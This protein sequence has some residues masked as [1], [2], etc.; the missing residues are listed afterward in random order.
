MPSMQNV[1]AV[2]SRLI[3]I[4][5][6]LQGGRLGEAEQACQ[7]LLAGAPNHPDAVHMLGLIREQA[8]DASAGEQLVRKSL[9]LE[10]GNAQYLLNLAH[11]L[12]RRGRLPEAAQ[13]YRQSLA[14][15]PAERAARYSLAVTL[16]DLGQH[17]DAERECRTLLEQGAEDADAWA[18]LAFVLGDQGRLPEAELAYRRALSID[19]KHV[20]AH[21]NLGS[22]LSRMERAE[23]ALAAL[24][25]ARALGASGFELNFNRGRT[26][27]L[28]YRLDEAER[29]FIEA[30]KLRPF[31]IDAQVNLA[32]LRFMRADAAFARDI[33]AAATAQPGNVP[34]QTAFA[35]VLKG[36]GAVELAERH[37]RQ[38]MRERGALP[39]LRS[40][41]AQLLHEAGRLAEA[42]T[43]ALEA[44]AARPGDSLIIDTLVLILLS[45]GRAHDALAFLV[46]QRRREPLV[47]SW[48]AYEATAA[49]LL[50]RDE[51]R[52]LYDYDWLVR[53]FELE[54]PPGWTSMA[55][56]NAALRAALQPRHQLA[57]HPL[58]QS[59]RHGSQTTRNLLSEDDAAIKA[60][61][62]AFEQPIAAYLRELGDAPS[63][64]LAARNRGSAAITGAWSVQLNREGFHVNH[65]HPQGWIS[66]AYYVNVPAEVQDPALKSG[67]LKFGETRF[68]V[69]GATPERFI[70]PVPGR[71][72]LFPSY[73][74]H[75]TNPIHGREPRLSIAFDA[76]PNLD[77]R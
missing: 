7:A 24:E 43:E 3:A 4:T 65:L 57:L 9:S 34:L 35:T 38:S 18:L 77:A 47:Q 45:R 53:C 26:L 2:Q 37:L 16:S 62:R 73:M 75:G 64:P 32:R 14:R 69:P 44:A 20:F 71:L 59:L 50:G 15:T 48:I 46:P 49:R 66:S 30:L 52:E 22:L 11:L 6:M 42:E 68:P 31:D 5:H 51:Y 67:W 27:S 28:L 70:Q 25:R 39:E 10:P 12:R 8:G 54:P 56:L 21:H 63:H 72:V 23:E 19:D 60:V 36:A 61:L 29:A 1:P 74:W 55:E 33:A 17:A 13:A 76:I 40:L 58:D 41:L